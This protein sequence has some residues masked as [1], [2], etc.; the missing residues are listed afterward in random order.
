MNWNKK[1]KAGALQFVLFIG[2]IV[3]VLLMSFVLVSY[4]HV[5][6]KKK[7]DVTIALIQASQLGLERSFKE[8][9]L[10][11]ERFRISIEKET[12]IDVGVQKKYWGL[13]EQRK[14]VAK[15][16][17]LEF[18]KI[19]FVGQTNETRPAL[20]LKDNQRPMVIVGN[21]R[22]KGNARLPQRGIKRGNIRGRGY[23]GSQLIY[24]LRENSTASLPQLD[25]EIQGQLQKLTQVFFL[26]QGKEIKMQNS[27]VVQNSFKNETKVIKGDFLDLNNVTLVGNV[28]VWASQKI[29]IEPSSLLKDVVLVAPQIVIKK[30][31]KGNFQAIANDKIMVGKGCLLDYPTLLAV[32]RNKSLSKN[33]INKREPNI[34]IGEQSRVNGMVIYM[35]KNKPDRSIANIKVADNAF[36]TG[37]VQCEG[38]LELKG[39][40]Y[41]RVVTN[42]FIALENG[43]AYQNHLFDGTID[44]FALPLEYAGMLYQGEQPNHTIKWLY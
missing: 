3:A 7:T 44:Q 27:L 30:G 33:N 38:N 41:G 40:I 29:V 5:L 15:K 16:G 22:I 13:L 8:P 11:E 6:F 9:L 25:H 28:M 42:A 35:D 32:Q 23:T 39:S 24:G 19:G 21:S 14:A 31:V 1:I 17:Q 20:Y 2:A 37:E 18:T 4:S 26:P 43:S 36:V 34:S 10:A 12:K